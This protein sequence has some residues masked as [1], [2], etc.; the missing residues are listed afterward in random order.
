VASPPNIDVKNVPNEVKVQG[1]TPDGVEENV[2]DGTV[3]LAVAVHDD[4]HCV[5]HDAL[6]PTHD[7]AHLVDLYDPRQF[8]NH[9]GDLLHAHKH[10][11]IAEKEQHL[12]VQVRQ[13]AHTVE[14][15]REIEGGEM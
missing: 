12:V 4:R 2:T 10:E 3:V 9:S 14:V 7:D 11:E 6:S 8:R 15:G 1:C 5:F 13:A